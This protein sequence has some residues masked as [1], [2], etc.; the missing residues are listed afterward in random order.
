MCRSASL[1]I[2]RPENIGAVVPQKNIGL[3][4]GLKTNLEHPCQKK[5]TRFRAL[6]PMIDQ[7]VQKAGGHNKTSKMRGVHESGSTLRR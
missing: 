7:K 2:V 6:A 1:H 5:K 3:S 4:P